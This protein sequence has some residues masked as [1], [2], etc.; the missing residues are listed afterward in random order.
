MKKALLFTGICILVT[1]GVLALV[2]S[3]INLGFLA[4]NRVGSINITFASN[5][6][7]GVIAANEEVI[8]EAPLYLNNRTD[9]GETRNRRTRVPASDTFSFP[10]HRFVHWFDVEADEPL[11][12]HVPRGLTEMDEGRTFIAIWEAIT[13]RINFNTTVASPT[14]PSPINIT[15]GEVIPTLPSPTRHGFL[16]PTWWTE[17]NG[18]GTEI[19][20]GNVF[21]QT[22][23][24]NVFA[25][26]IQ[27]P[28]VPQNLFQIRFNLRYANAS[29]PSG[30]GLTRQVTTHNLFE[31][32]PM[33]ATRPGSGSTHIG[34][35]MRDPNANNALVAVGNNQAV[36]NIRLANQAQVTVYALWHHAPVQQTYTVSFNPAGGLVNGSTAIHTITPIGVA[37][38]NMGNP[39]PVPTRT[40]HTFLGW[41]SPAGILFGVGTTLNTVVNTITSGN[42]ITLTAQWQQDAIPVPTF[43]LTFDGNNGT[44]VGPSV[45]TASTAIGNLGQQVPHATRGGHTLTGWHF[46]AAGI[47]FGTNAT[48]NA[49]TNTIPSGNAA[50]LVAQWQQDAV[51][52]PQWNLNFNPNSGT[53]N[54]STAIHSV[55][56]VGAQFSNL[57]HVAPAAQRTAH[58][59]T[60]WTCGVTGF[61]R[62]P[63]ATFAT[64]TGGIASGTT[65]TLTAQWDELPITIN[66]ILNGGTTSNTTTFTNIRQSNINTVTF[67]T[68]TRA[69]H[70]LTAWNLG[71]LGGTAIATN[72][73]QAILNHA[74]TT[75]SNNVSVHANW[76]AQTFTI[77]Y[78]ATNATIFDGNTNRGSQWVVGVQGNNH[79]TIPHRV[80]RP[81]AGGFTYSFEGWFYRWGDAANQR[82]HIQ[83][84]E[85]LRAFILTRYGANVLAITI[86]AGWTRTAI[87]GG[88]TPAPTQFQ[89][90][91]HF[92]DGT[93]RFVRSRLMSAQETPLLSDIFAVQISPGVY[94]NDG[95]LTLEG[96]SRV[97]WIYQRLGTTH[98]WPA[99]SHIPGYVNPHHRTMHQHDLLSGNSQ[100]IDGV[101][102]IHL[103]AVWIRNR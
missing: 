47:T 103:H 77:T 24:L 25:H 74:R 23:N 90:F 78:R 62:A 32:L 52:Q 99:G 40:S 21:N 73:Q 67:P 60:G 68:V 85:D 49:I 14:N 56:N 18:N 7:A 79:H 97:A 17:R 83:N 20:A 71:H 36:A 22:S 51:V 2:L 94:R 93:N 101:R 98:R 65:I 16:A 91:M 89:F 28:T 6:P 19:T 12:N 96:Y 95:R 13:Y 34:W 39:V 29:M 31:A 88:G 57:G 46:P 42:A 86:D 33:P 82:R 48:L 69:R 102:V 87:G 44:V 81:N 45:I 76:T 35:E 37:H 58:T 3:S 8:V 53:I 15:Y 50:T 4:G 26:W 66:F 9:E 100:T 10:G 80:E 5:P 41:Q 84:Y 63:N 59:L 43:T 55:P 38:S 75:G 54:G 70:N 1:F 11:R 72:N 61:L 64:I 30:H 27:D 92:M